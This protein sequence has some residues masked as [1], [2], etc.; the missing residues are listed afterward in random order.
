MR[1]LDPASLELRFHAEPELAAPLRQHLRSWLSWLGAK[2]DEIFDV[3]IA[4]SEAFANAVEHP[5]ERRLD[6]IDVDGSAAGD[7][8]TLSVRDYGSWQHDRL[9]PGG[10]GFRLM[11]ELMDAV[12]VDCWIDGTTI[13]M[14]RRLAGPLRTAST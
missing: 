3:L 4:V 6:Q 11:R 12:E 14:R 8:I 13:T 7:T 2:S 10:N 9:R 1:A 5:R